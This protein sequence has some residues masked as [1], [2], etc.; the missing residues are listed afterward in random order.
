MEFRISDL[1]IYPIKSLGGISIKSANALTEGF[2]YD[3]RWMLVDEKGK[4]LSQRELPLMSL[5]KCSLNEDHI[6]VD[7][8]QDNILIPSNTYSDVI[9]EVQVWK[10]NLKAQEVDP[11]ISTWFSDLLDFKCKLVA[12]TEISRRNKEFIKPPFSTNVSFADGFPYL[13]LGS[14]SLNLLNSKLKIKL[15]TDKFRANIL[16]ETIEAHQEDKW[17]DVSAGEAILKII[18]P[19]ARCGITT[20]NQDTAE[21]GIEPLRTLAEYRKMGNKVLFGANAIAIENGTINVGDKIKLR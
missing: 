16:V 1:F 3:R 20:I 4:F 13:I 21:K 15:P 17:E 8:K 9:K 18:K 14:E 6:R 19:C 2:E 5:F 7:F 11:L 10:S 12:M